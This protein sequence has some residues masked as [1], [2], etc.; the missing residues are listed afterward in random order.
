MYISTHQST[1]DRGFIGSKIVQ[2]RNAWV[3]FGAVGVEFGPSH[4]KDYVT[5]V[6]SNIGTLPPLPLE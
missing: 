6:S 3:W 4:P 5:P 1:V 2:Y